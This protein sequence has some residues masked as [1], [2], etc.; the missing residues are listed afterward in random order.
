MFDEVITYFEER[1]NLKLARLFHRFLLESCTIIQKNSILDTIKEY[2]D[3]IKEKDV[4][5]IA[6]TKKLEIKYLIA[7]D[8]D[9]KNFDEYITPNGFLRIM[10]IKSSATEY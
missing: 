2:K 8:K 10:E 9:V 5:Q 7:Y 6:V 3:K 1:H 4:E